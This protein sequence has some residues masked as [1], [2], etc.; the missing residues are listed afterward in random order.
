M[1]PPPPSRLRRLGALAATAAAAALLLAGCSAPAAG[2]DS[3]AAATRTVSTAEGSVTV[4]TH[5]KRV[6]SIHSWTTESLYDLGVKPVAVEDSGEQYVPTRYL[7]E[8]KPADKVVTGGTVDYE[9]I[10]ALK[11]DLIVGVDVPYLKDAYKK[12]SAIAP[13]AFAPFS[14]TATWQ[15]YPKYT[16]DFV[17]ADAKLATLKSTYDS[18]IDDT[19]KEYADQLASVKWDVIQGGFDD[20]NY[21]I[22]STSSPVGDVLT[23]L[24]AQF[25]SATKDTKAGDNTSV[26]YERTDLLQDADQLI[27]YTN[28]DGSPANNIDKLFALAGYKDLPAVKAGHVVGTADFL[29]GSYSDAMGLLD[30]IRSAL[31]KQS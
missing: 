21:W 6:V 1:T 30:D 13:T 8:W 17:G 25:A 11:P 29:P 26:S 9:K 16:A 2:N 3:S 23:Q 28:N 5:P 31:K 15:D 24:G 22:Y 14:E 19:K 10:A 12:L 4:P 18:A 27:Y 7:D 20:G